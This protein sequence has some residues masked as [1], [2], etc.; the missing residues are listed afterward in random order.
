MFKYLDMFLAPTHPVL[1]WFH[2]FSH[3]FILS[4]FL[5]FPHS[6]PHSCPSLAH[7][8]RVGGT[9]ALL[10]CDSLADEILG[11]LRCCRRPCN[12]HLAIACA[13]NELSLFGDL[14][15]RTCQ[16][17]ILHESLAAFSQD[18]TDQVLRNSDLH[19]FLPTFCQLLCA[20]QRW[21]HQWGWGIQVTVRH[22]CG[23]C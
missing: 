17:L 12:G 11:G 1:P 10:V 8:L 5:R 4:G 13:W 22:P 16:L 19:H 7:L 3:L 9:D 23:G 14:N 18:G 15:S 21:C 6:P 2:S 20:Q